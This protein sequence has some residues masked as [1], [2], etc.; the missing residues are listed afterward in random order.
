MNATNHTRIGLKVYSLYTNTVS[1]KK[2]IFLSYIQN[3]P[4]NNS[5][6]FLNLARFN[7]E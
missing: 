4:I 1:E 6:I 5:D 7:L 3:K 2:N